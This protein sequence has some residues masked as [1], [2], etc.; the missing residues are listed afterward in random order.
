MLTLVRIRVIFRIRAPNLVLTLVRIR[1]RR[2]FLGI[3]KIIRALNLLLTLVRIRVR[4][5][6]L[7][8]ITSAV[9]K[10]YNARRL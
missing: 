10:T 3:I 2:S 4:H 6:F 9:G 1:V 5:S 8:I 7:G